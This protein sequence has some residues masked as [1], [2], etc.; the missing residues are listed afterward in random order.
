[1]SLNKLERI[2]NTQLMV[3]LL[4]MLI[5]HDHLTFTCLLFCAVTVNRLIMM[6]IIVH[7]VVML[8]LHV[9]VLKRRSIQKNFRGYESENC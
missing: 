4:A 2:L 9:R 5:L 1:M 7:I 3:K 6:L 8:M